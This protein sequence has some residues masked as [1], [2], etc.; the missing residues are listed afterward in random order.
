MKRIDWDDVVFYS[1]LVVMALAFVS[2]MGAVLA[3]LLGI[4]L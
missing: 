4:G 2:V 1:G 3:H